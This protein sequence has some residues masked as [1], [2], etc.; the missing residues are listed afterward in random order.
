MYKKYLQFIKEF[1][2]NFNDIQNDYSNLVILCIGTNSIIGDSIGPITGS[3]LKH[4]ENEYLKIYGTMRN[5][6]NFNNAKDVI[7]DIYNNFLK[8]YIITIDAALSNRK[9]AGEIV[10]NKGYIKIGKAL[11]RSICFYSNINI[12]CVV[13]R[14]LQ[15]K[16]ENIEELKK[17]EK[18]NIY[19]MS[20]IVSLGI[21]NVLK[22]VNIFV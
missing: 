20:E 14:N 8:P 17:V 10:L 22:N 16:E 7:N 11:E 21:E 19:E 12:N 4:L 15:L 13:G 3:N 6:L 5:T 2:N 18:K 9:K 1:E